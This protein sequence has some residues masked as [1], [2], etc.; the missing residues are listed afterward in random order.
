[1][2]H[3][4]KASAPG[5]IHL[6]GEHSSVYGKPAILTAIDKRVT[7]TIEKVSKQTKRDGAF[8]SIQRYLKKNHKIPVE[9]FL[10]STSGD[11]PVGRGLGSSAAYSAAL[12][13]SLFDFYKL[14][15]DLD[16]V[17]KTAYEGEKHIHGN[18]SGGDLAAVVYGGVIYFRKETENLKLIKKIIPKKELR[19]FAIDS[20]KASEST[21]EMVIKVS[22]QN[23]KKIEK[24]CHD[25]EALTKK[26][27]DEIV[28]GSD[29]SK[30]LYEAG[31][32]LENLG[33]VSLTA[34]K[35]INKLKMS[36]FSA[37]I[38]GGGG[39]KK[40]SGVLILDA[41]N[42]HKIKSLCD[43]NGWENFLV[44]VESEGVRLEK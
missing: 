3:I 23:K 12:T 41:K 44:Q 42:I 5:K 24:F 6:I 10:V 2:R 31:E 38:S 1:M 25:Q 32:N 15:F 8:L 11:L 39:V 34:K 21:K 29:I 20:G 17:Y 16:E 22:K 9:S 28:E 4:V 30:T 18:P 40:G 19:F 27:A 26:M 14:K 36:G 37:K 33:A 7:V 43:K 35:I 13:V